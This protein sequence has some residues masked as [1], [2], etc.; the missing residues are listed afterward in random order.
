MRKMIKQVLIVALLTVL[1]WAGALIADRQKLNEELIRLHVVA[2]SDSR[3]DQDIKLMVRDA[4]NKSLKKD[5]AQV[6]DPAMAY[7]YIQQNL[8][9]IQSVANETLKRAGVSPDAVVSLCKEAFDTRS[10]DT[11]TL[12]AGVYNALRITIGQG[13]GKNWWCVVFPGL[14]QSVT[15]TGFEETAVAAGF[16]QSLS[17]TLTGSDGYQIR[18]FLLDAIGRLE[19]KLFDT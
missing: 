1:V 12:P 14:C 4:V 3:E 15:V 16:S 19:N 5:L 9:K 13:L 6:T 17:D 2:N 18:F 7:D 10:Y 8:P 11:F